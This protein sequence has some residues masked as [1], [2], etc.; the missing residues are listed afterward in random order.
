MSYDTTWGILNF[1][2]HSS[3]FFTLLH[4][5]SSL[6]WVEQNCKG[7]AVLRSG[8]EYDITMEYRDSISETTRTLH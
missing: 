7:A 1:E 8:S 3:T 5:I 6:I 4:A 2:H